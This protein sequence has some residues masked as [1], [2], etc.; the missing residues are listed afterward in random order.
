MRTFLGLL[1]LITIT[2]LTMSCDRRLPGDDAIQ[3]EEEYREEDMRENDSF[4][5]TV[6]VDEGDVDI[7]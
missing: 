4:E 5:R 1:V 3:R 2:L 7:E 6:P